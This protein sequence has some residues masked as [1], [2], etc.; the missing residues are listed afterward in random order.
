M[1]DTIY[2]VKLANDNR[3]GLSNGEW[4][5]NLTKACDLARSVQRRYKQSQV[6][7]EKILRD[8]RGRFTVQNPD[9]YGRNI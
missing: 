5:Q 2:C 8:E 9:V 4:A 6:V 1:A 7:I 3:V